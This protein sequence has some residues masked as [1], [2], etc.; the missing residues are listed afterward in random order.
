M[1]AYIN[2]TIE[3]TI[4]I[5]MDVMAYSRFGVP[6]RAADIA[7]RQHLSL[8]RVENLIATLKSASL[9]QSAKGRRGGYYISKD[10][11]KM[12]VL[13]IFAA[14]NQSRSRKI[15]IETLA[16]EIRN[17]FEGYFKEC[18]EKTSTSSFAQL[19]KTH[20]HIHKASSVL[21]LSSLQVKELSTNTKL[22]TPTIIRTRAEQHVIEK[23]T[24]SSVFELGNYL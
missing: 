4:Q 24:A 18:I 15:V 2:H 8:S 11:Q 14:V 9:V 22:D 3:R 21:E 19:A 6:V 20:R 1:L 12:S 10:P 7:K 23:K 17:R 5:L 13:D 16:L